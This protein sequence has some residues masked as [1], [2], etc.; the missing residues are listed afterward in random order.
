L[1]AAG[2]SNVNWP[3]FGSEFQPNPV[4]GITYFCQGTASATCL[5]SGPPNLTQYSPYNYNQVL[6]STHGSYSRYNAMQMMWQKQTGRNTFMVNY[7]FSKVMGIRDGQTNNGNGN[8]SVID[9][10]NINNNYGP[11]AYDHTNIF[12]AVYIVGLPSVHSSNSF[13]TGALNNWQLSGTLQYQSGPPMQPNA[14]GNFNPTWPAGVSNQ[15]ILGTNGDALVPTLLC[16]PRQKVS[17]GQYFNP[18]CFGVPTRG[19]NGNIIM[20]Y[21]KGPA[22]F[23]TDLSVYK[24]FN[25][26]ERQHLE[27]RFNAFNFINHALPTFQN[28]GTNLNFNMP[29]NGETGKAPL[30]IGSRVIEL[31]L[32]YNF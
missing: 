5:T 21:I 2:L 30:T 6:V 9:V 10:F 31:A 19:T 14:S 1:I 13:V 29:N 8:G 27:F 17:S 3:G 7:T 32:K 23:D 20:P 28:G 25:L 12:N 24:T 16:D 26:T 4:T 11:L 18:G 22:F 15:S